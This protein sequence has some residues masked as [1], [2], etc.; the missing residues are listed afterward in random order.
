M[1]VT[2]LWTVPDRVSQGLWH[3]ALREYLE[4]LKLRQTLSSARYVSTIFEYVVASGRMEEDLVTLLGDRPQQ[5][6]AE[7]MRRLQVARVWLDGYEYVRVQ[8]EPEPGVGTSWR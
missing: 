6:G 4:F 7:P 3:R 8:K 2:S 5:D 1:V